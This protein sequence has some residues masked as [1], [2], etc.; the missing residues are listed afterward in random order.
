MCGGLGSFVRDQAGVGI[1]QIRGCLCSCSMAKLK[2]RPDQVK[3]KE[4]T[5]KQVEVRSEV[6]RRQVKAVPW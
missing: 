6:E 2:Q 3:E 4:T 5:Q 1:E